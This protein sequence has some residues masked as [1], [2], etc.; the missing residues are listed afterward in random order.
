MGIPKSKKLQ[1][2]EAAKE[3]Q[4][5]QTAPVD[6]AAPGPILIREVEVL[7]DFVAILQFQ[8]DTGSIQLPESS[9]KYTNEGMVVGI[10]PT[11][12]EGAN[13]DLLKIG[14]VVMFGE[15]GRIAEIFSDSPPYKGSKVIIISERNVVCRLPTKY[16]WEMYKP[17]A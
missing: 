8:V 15:R 7:N 13:K 16:E 14:D 12:A 1:E 10:G 9:E 2:E 11:V 17:D 5:A 4:V 3:Q 6:V